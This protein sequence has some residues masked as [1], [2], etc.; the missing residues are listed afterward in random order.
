MSVSSE[1]SG[2]DQ[3]VVD[4]DVELDEEN[5]EASAILRGEQNELPEESTIHE[6]FESTVKSKRD[7]QETSELTAI[8]SMVSGVDGGEAISFGRLNQIANAAARR[9]KQQLLISSAFSPIELG[10][11]QNQQPVVAIWMPPSEFRIACLM[12]VWKMGGVALLLDHSL[13][14]AR[15]V[16]MCDETQ[17]S[18]VIVSSNDPDYRNRIQNVF[19][20]TKFQLI[21][22]LQLTGHLEQENCENLTKGESII[23]VP[24]A[25]Q[26][27]EAGENFIKA[28]LAT[29]IYTSGSTGTKKGV[30]LSHRN[31]LNRLSWQWLEIAYRPGDCCISKTSFI[32]VDFLTETLGPLL[33]GVRLVVVDKLTASDVRRFIPLVDRLR[34]TRLVV[35]PSVLDTMLNYLKSISNTHGH[36]LKHLKLVICSGETLS[37]NLALRF[38]KIMPPGC[39]L[40]NFYGSTEVTGD[41]TYQLFHSK[42]DVERHTV[43]Y[44]LSIG[45]VIYNNNIYLVNDNA[46][47]DYH[48]YQLSPPG[49]IG[50]I[51]VSGANV[52]ERYVHQHP[53][54]VNTFVNNPFLKD[55]EVNVH[56]V[57]YRTG[58][59]GRIVNNQLIFEGRKDGIIK[60][61]GQKVSLAE[62]ERA[63]TTQLPQ[64]IQVKVIKID[65][66]ETN[67]KLLAFYVSSEPLSP[68][69]IQSKTSKY[70][71]D[72]ITFE[73]ISV[74]NALPL[75]E[76]TGKVDLRALVGI[77][78][79]KQ[80]EHTG[81]R[82]PLPVNAASHALAR[83]LSFSN[84]DEID[85]SKSFFEMGGHSLNSVLAIAFLQQA[86]Y[87]TADLDKLLRA[88]TIEDF[89]NPL[90]NASSNAN[91]AKPAP[92]PRPTV[93]PRTSSTTNYI[94][95]PRYRIMKLDEVPE[96]R[97]TDVIETISKAFVLTNPLDVMNGTKFETFA[98]MIRCK[99]YFYNP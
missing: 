53:D 83:A 35:V 51:Y 18:G 27:T 85:G 3:N 92:P 13:P 48:Q 37:Y 77:Y 69:E 64:V 52:A 80:R 7:G 76:H 17:P 28:P 36:F 91:K 50:A 55:D 75:Q 41:V 44:R 39:T 42:E 82:K 67:S 72:Y 11:Q 47:S 56:Q 46:E 16:S 26:F 25:A 19:R 68:S 97:Y 63:I 14:D 84:V 15:I 32:F 73:A 60:I 38:F 65:Q 78:K 29:I 95:P 87:P 62:L 43:N 57:L 66:D 99:L 45:T 6:Y 4:D 23:Y 89:I 79:Q 59:Y 71:P 93:G 90:V 96:E 88:K 1:G 54:S 8:I 40:A 10:S 31:I 21:D 24:S 20:R 34:V 58:D 30:C 74:K 49:Q 61:R 9:L 86:G 98:S 33:E 70:L 22:Q 2:A 12:A 94:Q 5:G 81:K